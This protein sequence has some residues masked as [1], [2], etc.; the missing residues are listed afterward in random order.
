M[1]LEKAE[2]WVS[3]THSAKLLRK[4]LKASQLLPWT[5]L[6]IVL[7][8]LLVLLVIGVGNEPS[9]RVY[10]VLVA[11]WG[12]LGAGAA[13]CSALSEFSKI[14]RTLC[15]ARSLPAH[16]SLAGPHQLTSVRRK[17]GR[18][19]TCCCFCS[20]RLFSPVFNYPLWPFVHYNQ[21]LI[22]NSQTNWC[23]GEGEKSDRE[24]ELTPVMGTADE[25]QLFGVEEAPWKRAAAKTKASHLPSTPEVSSL[26]N[27]LLPQ[28]LG[29]KTIWPG[30]AG[31]ITRSH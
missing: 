24:E 20:S 12:C 29:C 27:S 17:Q 4:L 9:F 5:W 8:G 6:H 15:P 16:T 1:L 10:W 21:Q 31:N 2:S 18:A 7:A 30:F 26:C 19:G 11:V 3:S 14:T 13:S 28:H 25:K 22:A 23:S